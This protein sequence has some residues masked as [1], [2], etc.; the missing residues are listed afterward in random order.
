[1]MIMK[2]IIVK[3]MMRMLLKI[4]KQSFADVLQ[5]RLFLKVS[6]ISQKDTY[7][8]VS[9]SIKLRAKRSATLLKTYS[10][11]FS[12]EIC[13]L[14]KNTYFYRTPAVAASKNSEQPQ[15]PEGVANSSYKI[16]SPILLQDFAISKHCSGALLLVEDVTSCHGFGNQK[17]IF[18][19]GAILFN[20]SIYMSHFCV[21]LHKIYIF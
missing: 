13:E 2:V 10:Q 14:F 18:R 21:R 11:A 16:A 7:I 8:G 17:H 5:N 4:Q 20:R 15:L 12:Y 3:M 9:F 6:Q 19:K 1:M